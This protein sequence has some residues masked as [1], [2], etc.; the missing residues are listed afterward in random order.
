VR[1]ARVLLAVA[2]SGLGSLLGLGLAP[3]PA[4]AAEPVASVAITLTSMEPEL[5]TR[6]GEVTVTGRVTNI[7]KERLYRL[8]ALFWRNQAP[9]LGRDGLEQAL[10]SESNDPLGA[11]HIGAFQ[12]L[13]TAAKPYLEPNA[14]VD[15]RLRAKVT[16]LELSPTEGVYLMGVHVLQRGNNVA[17]G[18]ARTLVPVLAAKPSSSLT[19]T[20][21]V[22]L[23]SR[24]S[25]VRKGVLSDDHLA[26][27][28]GQ[29]GRLTALLKAAEPPRTSFAVDPAL[30]RELQTMA[31]G[32]QVLDSEGTTSAGTGQTDAARWLESFEFLKSSHDGFQLLYGSPDIAA[33]VHDGQVGVLSDAAN[34]NKLVEATRSLPL[35]VLPAGGTAD[36][37]TAEAAAALQPTAV[38][39][40]DTSARG[41]APL[42]AGP[43]QVPIVRYA[44]AVEDGGPGPDPR[45]TAVQTRQRMLTD[46][47]IEATAARDNLARGQV[48]LI[49][50]AVQAADGAPEL[51]A[52]WLK[53]LTLSELLRS[54]PTAWS[55]KFHY[56]EA[57]QSAQLTKGQL[58]SL[59]RFEWSNDTYADL[60]VDPTTA[61]AEG[62]AAVA[63]A[64][65]AKWR[66]NDEARRAFLGPQ[67]AALDEILLDRIQIRSSPRVQTVAREGVEFPITITNTLE[68][69]GSGPDAGAVKVSLVFNSENR[70]RLTIKTIKAPQIRA[71]DSFTGNAEVTA[72]A[73]GVVPVTAQLMTESGRPIGRP[74]DIEVQVTQNGTTG[75]AI[76]I[77]A[78]IVLVGTTFLRIRQVAKE[79]ATAASDK[80]AEPS[81]AGDGTAPDQLP[82]LSS[83]P[84]ER[85]DV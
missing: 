72:K 70:Q 43:N 5:P 53:T 60:L 77:A 6:D 22:V 74:F 54:T 62:S 39:I 7:T 8:E 49:S 45:N 29:N 9:I 64:A 69:D 1:A 34:A 12:D 30:I 17:I 46:T 47:W 57:A 10:A 81:L 65:S 23:N 73:N 13:F 75:W 83:V 44:R 2:V 18:R 79:R 71:Q 32:Y 59:S 50:T 41:P 55:M 76:A 28:V 3:A 11:R 52:P 80:S 66:R 42:L 56:S 35:L 19:M 68:A 21:L 25:L 82:A 27:E 61:R 15:F 38:L 20:S 58:T 14:S 51:K 24:P 67:Q 31:G 26:A 33:L 4:V 78:G 63:L 16:D 40:A 36:A 37:A 85:L 84:A 48:R